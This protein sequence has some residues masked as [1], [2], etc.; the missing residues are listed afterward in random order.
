MSGRTIC[1]LSAPLAFVIFTGTFQYGYTFYVYN[2]LQLAVRNGVRYGSLMDYEGA[3]CASA[4]QN[5]V[6]NV[7]VYGT[8]TPASGASPVVRGLNHVQR[9]GQLKSGFE[10]CSGRR[11]S[12]HHRFLRERSVYDVHV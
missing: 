9:S 7:V 4:A 3:A 10:G 6:K 12:Q 5:T 1:A 11:H 2:Q 8:P